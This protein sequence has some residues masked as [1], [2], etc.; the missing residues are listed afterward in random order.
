MQDDGGIDACVV[1]DRR[2]Y[3]IGQLILVVPLDS[4]VASN[5]LDK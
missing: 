5:S 1:I 2:E 4:E 3:A